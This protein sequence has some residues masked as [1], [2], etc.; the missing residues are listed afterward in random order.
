MLFTSNEIEKIESVNAKLR[1]EVE[2]LKL[3][4]G[5]NASILNVAGIY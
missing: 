3:Q 1:Q 4:L 2:S 5:G